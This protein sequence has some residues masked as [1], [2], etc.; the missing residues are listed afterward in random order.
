MANIRRKASA[1]AAAPVPKR[2]G[3][4][5][6]KNAAGKKKVLTITID[7]ALEDEEEEEPHQPDAREIRASHQRKASLQQASR[8]DH[9]M[10]RLTC[11]KSQSSRK[12]QLHHQRQNQNL[13]H[14]DS[15][16]G[17]RL[18]R[19]SKSMNSPCPRMDILS[20]SLGGSCFETAFFNYE[21]CR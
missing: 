16:S 7:S 15:S 3:T 11:H 8:R 21:Y 9:N 6:A 20:L 1:Q 18:L 13:S 14:P 10:A 4:S 5:T 17:T 12:S 19:K 2:A